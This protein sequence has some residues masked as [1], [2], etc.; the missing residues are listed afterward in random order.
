MFNKTVDVRNG[1]KKTIE[2]TVASLSSKCHFTTKVYGYLGERRGLLFTCSEP[3]HTD[4]HS[5]A[6]CNKTED[7]RKPIKL[8]NVP[9]IIDITFNGSD[10]QSVLNIF[11]EIGQTGDI[12]TPDTVVFMFIC[13]KSQ[14]SVDDRY[15]GEYHFN[16]ST[17]G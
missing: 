1:G 17:R 6:L 15:F 13:N 2:D 7:T 3:V 8:E 11:L 9:I 12:N 5:S 16:Y 14:D 10:H 4:Q